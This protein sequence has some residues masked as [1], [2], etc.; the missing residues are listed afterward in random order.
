MERT[1]EINQINTCERMLT[2][3]QKHW[4]DLTEQNRIQDLARSL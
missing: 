2:L 1:F 3:S 4:Y